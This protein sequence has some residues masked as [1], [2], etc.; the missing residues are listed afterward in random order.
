MKALFIGLG[1]IG[2]RHLRNLAAVMPQG[3][4]IMAVRRTRSVP[5]LNE[6]MEVAGDSCHLVERYGITEF[7]ELAEALDQ[8]PDLVY[9]CNPSVFHVPDAYAALNSGAAV[10]IEKPLGSSWLGVDDLLEAATTG[11]I[12]VGFQFRFHPHIQRINQLIKAGA[13]GRIV[14]A[15]FVNSEYLPHW[16]SYEDY[17]H[18]YAAQTALGGGALLTQIHELDLAQWF[19]GR[20]HSVYAVGGHLSD[21]EVDVEDSVSVMLAYR[22]EDRS[23]PVTIHLDYLGYPAERSLTVTGDRGKVYWSQQSGELTI[24]NIEDARVETF[25]SPGFERNQMFV[26]Q[27]QHFL[28]FALGQAAP[29]VSVAEAAVSLQIALAAQESM[30]LGRPVA[31]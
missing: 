2:Q 9:V 26:E 22:S 3:F 6:Q 4:E 23:F 20:P 29:S 27:T 13:L 12:M 21:L 19:L 17:R 11:K 15:T 14:G 16:H 10:F 5:F 31:L 18:S 28:K 1:S 24:S 30:R 7:S 25:T 8:G